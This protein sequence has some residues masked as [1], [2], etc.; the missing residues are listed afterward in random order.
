VGGQPAVDG[1]GLV[2]G[3][4]VQDDVDVQAGRDGFVDGSQELPELDRPVP[5]VQRPDDLAGG[6]AQGG[7]Q[8]RVAGPPIQVPNGPGAVV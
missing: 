3:D 8:V 4:V 2:G 7:V 1:L 5:G 6:Q